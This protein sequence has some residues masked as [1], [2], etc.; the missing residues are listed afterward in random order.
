VC[1]QWQEPW[2]W[3][4][5]DPSLLGMTGSSGSYFPA[6]GINNSTGGFTPYTAEKLS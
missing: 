6:R 4:A 2:R 5:Q 1:P 3:Q